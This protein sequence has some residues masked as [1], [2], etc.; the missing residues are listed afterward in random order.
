MAGL[1]LDT[2]A[3]IAA[4]R[5]DRRFWAFWK[6]ALRRDIEV[7]IPSPVLAQVWRGG[8]E[9]RLAM[10]VN[11]CRIESLDSVLARQTGLLCGRS[12][13]SDVVDAFVVISAG[14]RR[15]DVLTSDPRDIERLASFDPRVGKIINLADL[16]AQ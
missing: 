7:T 8:R 12:G 10:L 3:L 9:A 14:R 4:E 13:T 16:P 11:G 15:D 1:T 6:E 2:G 5:G